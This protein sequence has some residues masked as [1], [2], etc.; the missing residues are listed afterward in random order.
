MTIISALF[1]I[2]V[3]GWLF[4]RQDKET[5]SLKAELTKVRAYETDRNFRCELSLA[6]DEANR[7]NNPASFEEGYGHLGYTV[8]ELHLMADQGSIEAAG[9]WPSYAHQQEKEHIEKGRAHR[10][11]RAKGLRRRAE[12]IAHLEA[13]LESVKAY[14]EQR[15]MRCLMSF[16][17]D[18]A[19]IT[20]DPGLFESYWSDSAYSIEALNRMADQGYLEAQGQWPGYAYQWRPEHQM[21]TRQFMERRTAYLRTGKPS[22]ST[23]GI[24]G[25]PV[26]PIRG[27]F[28]QA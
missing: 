4:Y 25:K 26:Y 11:R 20:N 15:N 14:E 6:R 22:R 1:G 13:E 28:T 8:E 27:A 3:V 5:N 24:S 12:R 9:N 2:L 18:E 21:Q 16:D 23:I 17:R 19:D 10:E 7:E